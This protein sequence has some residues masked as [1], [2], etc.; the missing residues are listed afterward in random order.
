M[1]AVLARNQFITQHCRISKTSEVG[2]L[3]HF[4]KERGWEEDGTSRKILVPH[5]SKTFGAHN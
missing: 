1:V 2:P 4:F 5:G 3:D